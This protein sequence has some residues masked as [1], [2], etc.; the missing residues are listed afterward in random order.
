MSFGGQYADDDAS[1]SESSEPAIDGIDDGALPRG[2]RI[3]GAWSWRLVGIA[4]VIY[5]LIAVIGL[6]RIV[7]IPI[8]VALLLAALVAV[9]LLA[10]ANTTIRYLIQHPAGERLPPNSTPGT[11]PTDDDQA[12][13]EESIEEAAQQTDPDD[14]ASVH[15][16]DTPGERETTSPGLR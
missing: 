13:V 6:L 14:P 10:V 9:P 11:K 12:T 4:L 1:A 16:P 5:G 7:V 8:V 3:V 15:D 2:L